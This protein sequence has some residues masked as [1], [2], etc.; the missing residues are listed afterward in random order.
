MNYTYI[1]IGII[2]LVVFIS[3]G[4]N[5]FDKPP[6]YVPPDEFTDGI[7][8]RL[9]EPDFNAGGF[10]GSGSGAYGGAYGGPSA[11]GRSGGSAFPN[12]NNGFLVGT[13]GN[14]NASGNTPPPQ[15]NGSISTPGQVGSAPSNVL[16]YQPSISNYDANNRA[17]YPTPEVGSVA[18]ASETPRPRTND[19]PSPFRNLP[20]AGA[21]QSNNQ[22]NIPPQ[23]AFPTSPP[24]ITAEGA[25]LKFEG[26][27]VFTKDSSGKTIY[28][29][30]GNYVLADGRNLI[31]KEG[32]KMFQ[33]DRD[34]YN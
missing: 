13:Y 31:V 33:K 5:P 20:G 21:P 14:D 29:P 27:E 23:I 34:F 30:D 12:N 19:A 22:Q 18:P 15:Y 6:G 7:K 28:M 1:V 9:E 24:I 2:L 25:P 16:N 26:A 3:A 17:S 4:E 11:L 32:A 10:G 8:A